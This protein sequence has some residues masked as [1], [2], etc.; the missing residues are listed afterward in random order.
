MLLMWKF[1]SVFVCM[2]NTCWDSISLKIGVVNE[3]ACS[4]DQHVRFYPTVLKM[5]DV[6]AD[7]TDIQ[8]NPL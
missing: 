1:V 5:G 8:A 6:F 4:L 3:I 7:S 2:P